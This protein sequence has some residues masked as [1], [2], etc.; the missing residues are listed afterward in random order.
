[1][2]TAASEDVDRSENAVR[3]QRDD[4]ARLAERPS[5]GLAREFWW[6]IRD[7]KAWWLV[8]LLIGLAVLGAAVWVGG[9]AAA[10]FIY[11]LI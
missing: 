3:P 11:P 6:F 8:P 4:F 2:S 10:P 9:S 5:P 1:M 7:H